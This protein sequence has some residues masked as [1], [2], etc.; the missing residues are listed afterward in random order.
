MLTMT[1]HGVALETIRALRLE[2]GLQTKPNDLML[3]LR[4]QT[5]LSAEKRDSLVKAY[6]LAQDATHAVRLTERLD[7][8]PSEKLKRHLRLFDLLEVDPVSYLRARLLKFT[9]LSPSEVEAIL[10]PL[11]SR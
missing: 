7:L 10:A 6:A 1:T 8:A 5:K 3:A 4:T 2:A 11:E 9:L